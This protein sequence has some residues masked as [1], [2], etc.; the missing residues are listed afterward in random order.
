[1][2]KTTTIVKSAQNVVTSTFGGI[3]LRDVFRG[4]IIMVLYTAFT[5]IQAALST[6]LGFAAVKWNAIFLDVTKAGLSYI[7]LNALT[8]AKVMIT[9][10]SPQ[11]L[12]S[13]KE[14]K[15]EAKKDEKPITLSVEVV[16]ANN[17]G[18]PDHEQQL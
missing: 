12:Q 13:V 17:D 3:N 9:N 4:L 18:I 5:G 16:D 6:E 2:M 10:P 7:I 8:P 14:A 1:M 15:E 11:F